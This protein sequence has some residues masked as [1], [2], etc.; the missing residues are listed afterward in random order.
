[1][2]LDG[3]HRRCG[4]VAFRATLI[5]IVVAGSMVF[6]LAETHAA[7]DIGVTPPKLEMV[8]GPG[9]TSTELVKVV[10][11]GAERV[12]FKAYVMDWHLSQTGEFIAIPPGSGQRSASPWITFSPVEFDLEPGGVQEVRVGISVPRDVSGGYRS[13]IFFESAPSQVSGAYGVAVA[14]RVGVVMYIIIRGTALRQGRV[15]DLS[16][17]YD[18]ERETL[19]GR[20]GFEN[21]GNVHLTLKPV[22]ELRDEQGRRIARMELA[23]A[24]SLPKSFLEIPFTWHG[25]LPPGEYILLAVIDYGGSSRVAGQIMFE[26]S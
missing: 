4:R 17:D 8:L 23:P 7:I 26:S 22:V 10:N 5:F 19:T 25:K 12:H 2:R 21:S 1:M 6:P 14:G 11:S 24:V 9:E 13:V 3:F 20:I 15:V 18:S 16:A